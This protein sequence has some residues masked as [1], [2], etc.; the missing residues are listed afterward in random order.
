M[1][2]CYVATDKLSMPGLPPFEHIAWEDN[3]GYHSCRCRQSGYRLKRDAEGTARS[4]REQGQSLYDWVAS[5]A[6]LTNIRQRDL[7]VRQYYPRI[8]R[9][10]GD[11]LPSSE[12]AETNATG[13]EVLI[14]RMRQVFKVIEPD[15]ANVQ[16]YG[17]E[18]RNLL[19]LACME[20]EAEWAAVLRANSY[21]CSRMTTKD[22]VKGSVAR[23]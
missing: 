19:L 2:T 20:V 4:G 16:A 23:A 13:I 5:H 9:P 21:A 14:D 7:Q 11:Y 3:G 18:I 10:G 6:H 1:T 17:H 22:Y 12:L 15:A 8:F